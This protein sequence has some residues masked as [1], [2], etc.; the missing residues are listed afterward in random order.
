MPPTTSSLFAD[1]DVIAEPDAPIGQM[2]W[3]GIGGR[4]DLLI[5]PRTLD[6]LQALARR[7]A[8][9]ETPLRILG[10]GANL[11]V[12]DE[13]VDGVVV[14]LDQPEFT[15][16]RYNARGALETM[17]AG[18]GADMARVL[19]DTVRRGLDGLVQ[20]AGIPA[21]IGGAI[22]MNAGG[23]YGAVGES[24]HSVGC[25][26]RSGE[27]VVYPRSELRFE[28]RRTNIP[29]P[30]VLWAAF[31]LTET[32]PVALRG[33]LKE[34]FSYK[35]STQPLAEHSAGCT[36]RNP[37]D[38]VTER[39]VPAGRLLDEAGLKGRSVG[40]ATVSARHANFIT[41]RPGTRSDDVRKLL[42]IMQQTVLE[43]SGYE[44]EPEISIWR[45]GEP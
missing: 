36:F 29:D 43:H 35:K 45:R 31:S 26:S 37:I 23:A 8:R 6:A 16:I 11:L 20:M 13:G 18:A 19:M 12:A 24:V 30:V 27:L 2:T 21:T 15:S 1:L 25:L 32:D 17:R 22:T 4:A 42:E 33:R 40:G 3:Y 41:V 38:P 10:A 34:I 5:R 14:R 44:L 9:T 39:R 28:Y 7:C